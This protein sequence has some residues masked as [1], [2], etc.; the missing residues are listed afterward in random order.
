MKALTIHGKMQIT[1]D[2]TPT[3]EPGEGQ[4]RLGM[5]YAGICGS[6]IHYYFNGANGEYIIKEPL[7]PGHEVSGTV[8]LDPSGDLLSM[9]TPFGP[10]SMRRIPA[11]VATRD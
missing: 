11:I 1:E 4:I 2:E 6:D 10:T 5:A 9:T 3:P 8:D 7:V